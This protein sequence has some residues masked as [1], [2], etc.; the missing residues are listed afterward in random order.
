MIAALIFTVWLTSASNGEFA[1]Y[2]IRFAE[3]VSGLSVG[4]SVKYRGVDVGSVESIAIDPHD[5][6]LILVII[7]VQKATPIKTDTV[8]SLK[9]QG[10]T[11]VVFIELTGGSNN[12]ADMPKTED[13]DQIPEIKAQS[14]PLSAIVDRLPELLDR[15]SKAVE[16]INKMVS[17]DNVA[18]ISADFAQC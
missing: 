1:K 17:D 13:P 6:K 16:Q 14:S 15:I 4:G 18:S 7:K 8:A 12:M 3:S 9:L 5:T 2:R 11:G 10:I